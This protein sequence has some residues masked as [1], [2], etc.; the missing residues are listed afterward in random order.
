MSRIIRATL[1][2]LAPA[3]RTLFV[4][5]ALALVIPVVLRAQQRDTFPHERHSRLFPSCT[6]CHQGIVS[7]E[8]ARVLPA[9]S[10]CAACH[11]G[12]AQRLVNWE[13]PAPRG[14]GLLAFSHPAHVATSGRDG[15]C[16]TSHSAGEPARWMNVAR[17]A[18]EKCFPCHDAKSHYADD[19]KCSTC[20]RTLATATALSD[21]RV[22]ALPKPASHARADFVST[23]GGAAGAA[24]PTCATC[25][26]RESCERCHANAARLQPI[27][28]LARDA[29]VARLVAGKAIPAP[30]D[31]RRAEFV[32]EHGSTARASAARCAA[33]HSRP[34]CA[35]CHTGEGARAVL[36]KLLRAPRGAA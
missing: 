23:H 35:T 17:A 18:P 27:A 9:A 20:H 24:S 4:S 22:A 10:Q 6:G 8:A 11:D 26:A 15:A 3:A 5:A 1:A 33:C 21:R 12:K 32:L 14:P 25:H 28:A 30:A 19:N 34:S 16:E 31:H 13:P 2:L 7:G 36:D 29:R